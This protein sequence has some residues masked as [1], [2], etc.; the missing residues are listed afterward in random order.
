MRHQVK[1]RRLSRSTGHRNMLRRSLITE[2][3]RHERI[4]T[5]AAKAK[6]VRGDAEKL[7]TLARN[8]GDAERLVDLATDGDEETLKRLLTDAQARR[9]L[10][11]AEDE[12]TLGREAYAIAAHAQRLVGK[13][14]TD[15][16][17]L[18]KLFSDIAPRFVDR[19]GGYTRLLKLSPRKG[20]R[21]EMVVLELVE[22]ES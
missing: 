9:L 19:N 8:R 3:F 6:A 10:A 21:A 13:E 16:E 12:E 20:D 22:R 18:Y 2:L 7:I 1:G 15:R 4:K 17:I 5:T 14:I 11:A